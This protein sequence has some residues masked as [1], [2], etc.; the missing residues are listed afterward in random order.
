MYI[1]GLGPCG[2]SVLSIQFCCEPNIALKNKL[3]YFKTKLC[4]TVSKQQKNIVSSHLF[5][6]FNKYMSTYYMPDILGILL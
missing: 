4:F 5:I 1:W 3:Y 6:S 2:D